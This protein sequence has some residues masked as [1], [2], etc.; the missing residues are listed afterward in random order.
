V[1]AAF[2]K[3]TR[4]LSPR[5]ASNAEAE[6]KQANN[7]PLRVAQWRKAYRNTGEEMTA[8]IIISGDFS[9]PGSPLL[10]GPSEDA[11]RPTVACVAAVANPRLAALKE[12]GANHKRALVI[13]HS[14][15]QEQGW[16]TSRKTYRRIAQ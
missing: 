8:I 15:D 13:N 7:S 16:V 11:L 1:A 4:C 14:F 9:E 6:I 12:L 10:A 2:S 5:F 3:S